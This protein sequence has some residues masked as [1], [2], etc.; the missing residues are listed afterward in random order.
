MANRIQLRRD[1]AANWTRENPILSQG[2]P[3]FDLTANKLKV[4][5]GVTAWADLAYTSG[6]SGGGGGDRL[7]NG[8]YE[9]V[10]DQDGVLNLPRRGAIRNLSG[11]YDVNVVGAGEDGFAQL[12]WTTLAGAAEDDPN[13]T[14]ELKHWL[15]I[16]EPGVFIE[17]NVNGEGDSYEW[18]F[19]NDGSLRFPGASDGTIEENETGLAITSLREFSIFA[20]SVES[21]KLWRFGTDGGLTFPD[22]TTSTTAWNTST[23][24][25]P[26]QIV[27]GLSENKYVE[28]T[29]STSAVVGQK[30]IVDTSNVSI[31]VT[32]PGSGTTGD[33]ITIIDGS[34]NASTHAIILDRNGGKIQGIASNMNVTTDRAAF[35]LVYYNSANG[36]ILTNV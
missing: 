31:T 24:V 1:T 11:T 28:I 34:G 6:S 17:T 35:T 12:Q 29:T 7:I 3:G 2:E 26:A 8:E 22:G 14:N 9:V 10:L 13:G 23:A 27:G 18:K 19:G 20:N 16:E 15:Y 33:E 21:F 25:W 4:G 30:Y 5:D 32:L 36:W